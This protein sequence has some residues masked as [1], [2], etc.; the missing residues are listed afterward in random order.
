M[1]RSVTTEAVLAAFVRPPVLYHLGARHSLTVVADLEWLAAPS[2]T[3]RPGYLL[4]DYAL[5]RDNP[6]AREQFEAAKYRLVQLAGGTYWP[7]RVVLLDD[8]GR[9]YLASD[10]S[11]QPD[12]RIRYRLILYRINPGS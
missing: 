4:V 10:P 1:D 7:G 9:A 2:A 12:D 11:E 8:L 3:F 6:R 5:W